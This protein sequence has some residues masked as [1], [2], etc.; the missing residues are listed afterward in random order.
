[1]ELKLNLGTTFPE[2]FGF[3]LEDGGGSEA[4]AS[5]GDESKLPAKRPDKQ[6]LTRKVE[7][8]SLVGMMRFITV[9][10]FKLK[11]PVTCVR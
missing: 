5:A 1:M 3:G 2:C 9:F 7:Q 11:R 4:A 8:G 10:L 6:R